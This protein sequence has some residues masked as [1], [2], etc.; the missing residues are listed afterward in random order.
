MLVEAF[1]QNTG[2][3]SGLSGETPK[4]FEDIQLVMAQDLSP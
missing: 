2:L 1:S 4:K 3:R